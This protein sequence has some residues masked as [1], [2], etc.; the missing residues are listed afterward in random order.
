MAELEVY[1][2]IKKPRDFAG[3]FLWTMIS[4][5]AFRITQISGKVC[6]KWGV[7]F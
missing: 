4:K 1:K 6:E 2:Y 3:I 5:P 7:C